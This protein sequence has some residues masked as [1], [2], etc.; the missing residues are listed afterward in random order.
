M[1]FAYARMNTIH[2]LW[3]KAIVLVAGLWVTSSAVH[4][5]EGAGPCPPGIGYYGTHDG[6]PSCGQPGGNNQ[7]PATHYEDRW[8][9]IATYEP[10]GVLGAVVNM[11]TEI[12]AKEAAMADC[13]AKGGGSNCKFQITYRNECV[14][15]MVGD[16]AFNVTPG[17]TIDRA[18]QSGMQ[19]CSAN[20]N[21]NCHTFYSACSPAVQVQ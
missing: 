7:T 11:P 4:A 17:V 15:I 21:S 8:G 9:A 14:V 1:H 6:I 13:R 2:R 12:G 19:I 5:Q 20:G 3:I 16:R 10:S 18:T